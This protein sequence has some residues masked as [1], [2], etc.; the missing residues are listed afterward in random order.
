M[1]ASL[2]I[3]VR[4]LDRYLMRV[5]IMTVP[6]GLPELK[7]WFCTDSLG[8]L[9]TINDFKAV[10]CS[11]IQV[12]KDAGV[13]HSNVVLLLDDFELL[14]ESSVHVVR[15]GDLICIKPSCTQSSNQYKTREGALL[16]FFYRRDKM[17][18]HIY[19]TASNT[20]HT[21]WSRRTSINVQK[22]SSHRPDQSLKRK[23]SFSS[24]SE[25]DT[26]SEETSST[27]ISSSPSSTASPSPSSSSI[28]SQ[29]HDKFLTASY[30]NSKPTSA[31]P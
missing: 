13:Q 31:P 14:N 4:N 7:A 2:A 17:D 10:L 3:A 29:P 21:I 26:G 19:C 27:S 12:L 15:D 23:L 6:P 1:L 16:T 11:H 9:D 22:S 28:I 24:R 18:S 5:R 20:P 30:G 25:S 8:H